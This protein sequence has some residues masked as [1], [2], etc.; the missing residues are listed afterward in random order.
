MK[1]TKFGSK[2]YDFS[3]E[4]KYLY[5]LTWHIL[6]CKQDPPVLI[7]EDVHMFQELYTHVGWPLYKKYGHAFDVRFRFVPSQLVYV[8][9]KS[10]NM[11]DMAQAFKLIVSDPD[12]VLDSLT[13]RVEEINADGQKVYAF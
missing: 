9:R 4:I 7:A 6:L 2:N 8:L 13:R 11:V 5:H 10:E 1:F 3:A 12:S